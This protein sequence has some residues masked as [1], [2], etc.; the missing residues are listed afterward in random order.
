[1]L[2]PITTL[3]RFFNPRT[4]NWDIHF[5]LD[6][7]IIKAKTDIGSVTVNILE[8]NA[9]ERLLERA[10]LIKANRYPIIL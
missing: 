7:E 3:I 10:E 9:T 6:N 8:L 2:L 4:D 1:M 5:Y